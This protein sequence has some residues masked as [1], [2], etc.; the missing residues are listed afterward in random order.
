MI[1]L[2]TRSK[3][4]LSLPIALSLFIISAS[5]VSNGDKRI[6][7]SGWE[8]DLK[9]LIGKLKVTRTFCQWLDGHRF[10]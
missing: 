8:E 3:K 1:R 4:W 9:Y 10:D 5:T 2:F 6:T 7:T